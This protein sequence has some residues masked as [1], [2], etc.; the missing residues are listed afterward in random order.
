MDEALAISLAGMPDRDDAELARAATG[1]NVVVYIAT[2]ATTGRPVFV[3]LQ[4]RRRP[5]VP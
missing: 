2:G 1:A 4:Q 5:L 3:D